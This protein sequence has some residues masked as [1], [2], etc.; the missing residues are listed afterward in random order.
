RQGFARPQQ[1][2]RLF[3][4]REV[5]RGCRPVRRATALACSEAGS[6]GRCRRLK[7]GCI[8]AQRSPRRAAWPAIDTGCA[9]P[10][11]ERSVGAGVTVLDRH[12]ASLYIQHL[13]LLRIF[14][15]PKMVERG[16]A[17]YPALAV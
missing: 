1:R 13:P 17:L 3:D 16:S 6:F 5:P 7:E 10:I 15:E 12:P 4:R 9:H 14:G 2:A 11:K 8:S